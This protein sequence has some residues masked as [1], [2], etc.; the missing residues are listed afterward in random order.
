MP[1]IAATVLAYASTALPVLA[2]SAA[3]KIKVAVLMSNAGDPYFANKSYG[4]Q[5]YANEDEGIELEFFNA[6]GY[7]KLE[8]QISQIENAIQRAVDVI[9][10]T[11]IDAKGVCPAVK[12][13][14]DAG[15]I[16][17]ADDTGI[18]CD[19]KVPLFITEN[20]H[21]T[22]FQQCKFLA[23]YIDGQGGMVAMWGAPGPAHIRRRQEG[24][25]EALKLF[26][27]VKLLVGQ[28]SQHGVEDGLKLTENFLTAYGDEV[29][30]IYSA[31]SVMADGAAR[32]LQAAGY[33]PGDIPLVGIDMTEQSVKM[34]NDGWFQG[35]QPAQPVRLAY[36]LTK[37]G[38][39]LARGQTIPGESVF[40]C[41]ERVLL[42]TD[43]F[44]VT[45]EIFKTFPTDLALA[46]PDW[47][48]PIQ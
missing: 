33:K 7:D 4:Y 34:M 39:A 19:F 11:P 36:L 48:P 14:M 16:V 3:E 32:A 9:L 21:E 35:I 6:G 46:P 28:H 41:C 25:L 43:F 2:Q 26:P 29:K 13:A 23:E 18:E 20:S 17:V 30:A 42:T 15:I 1:V 47:A 40:D 5:V 38:V 22:G 8:V 37:Y 12:E 31:G 24:C 45:P 27:N 10:V 44:V